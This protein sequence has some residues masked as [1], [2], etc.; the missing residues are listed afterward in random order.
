MLLRRGPRLKDVYIYP[1]RDNLVTEVF[2]VAA[3]G[4]HQSPKCRDANLPGLELGMDLV[5]TR[6]AVDLQIYGQDVL[7][8]GLSIV[9]AVSSQGRT[10]GCK[11]FN[12]GRSCSGISSH[13]GPGLSK[14]SF[15][16]DRDRIKV[17]IVHHP[18]LWNI[19][20]IF[21]VR[22]QGDRARQVGIC[23][24]Q[25]ESTAARIPPTTTKLSLSKG[26]V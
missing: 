17:E 7:T 21:F 14:R 12:L 25:L 18:P 20:T 19:R 6:Q 24:W 9:I 22:I 2:P 10:D 26:M 1:G 16:V 15:D 4:V 5:R 23:Q 3:R 11:H 13:C 8:D